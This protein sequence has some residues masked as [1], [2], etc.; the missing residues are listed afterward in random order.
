MVSR[1]AVHDQMQVFGERGPCSSV[2]LLTA[3]AAEVGQANALGYTFRMSLQFSDDGPE[4]PNAL[5]DDLARGEVVFLC[6]A[7]VSAPQMPGFKGLVD[8]IYKRRNWPCTPGEQLSFDKGRYEEGLGSL[9]RRLAHP[10]SLYDTV[11]SILQGPA[12]PDFSNHQTLLRLSRQL[13]NRLTIV[14]TNFDTM[15]ER[16]VNEREGLTAANEIS[17]AGQSLPAP[18]TPDFVGI[19][20]LHGRLEDPLLDLRRTPLVL[21]SAEYGDAYMRSGWAS[22]FL[23]DLTRCRTV[24]LVGYSAN[25]APVRYFLN[26]LEADRDR[27]SDLRTVYALDG[28][29]GSDQQPAFD[30]WSA[31]AVRTLL[32]CKRNKD[33][34]GGPHA[35]LWG[36]LALL[37]DLIEQPK[38]TRLEKAEAI[39]RRSFA[40]NTTRDQD[41]LAW[42]F[43]R[44]ADVFNL[45]I[46]TIQDPAWM[47]HLLERNLVQAQDAPWMLAEWCAKRWTDQA[48]VN[49][50]VRWSDRLGA[51]F[52]NE[53]E[54]R[55]TQGQDRPPPEPWRTAWRLL[56]IAA[57]GRRRD[58]DLSVFD[59]GVFFDHGAALDYDRRRAVRLMTPVLSVRELLQMEKEDQPTRVEDILRPTMEL[60]DEDGLVELVPSLLEPM[61]APRIAEL[62]TEELSSSLRIARDAGLISGS[63]D[64]PDED[65]PSVEAHPQNSHFRGFLPLVALLVQ[66]LDVIAAADVQQARRLAENWSRLESR[67][68]R[69]LWLHAMRRLDLFQ[70]DEAL[71]ALLSLDQNDFWT[72]RREWVQVAVE[73]AQ[74]AASDQI[75]ALVNRI[76]LEAPALYK[77][78][79]DLEE[80]QTDWRSGA[81]DRA[82][83]LRLSALDRSGRLNEVGKAS[84]AQIKA[85]HLRLD[86]DYDDEDL[87]AIYS[88]GVHRVVGNP[89]PLLEAVPGERLKI[90]HRLQMSPI[91]DDHESWSAYA[92]SDPESA[93][94]TLITGD[95]IKDA[96][97]W[98]GFLNMIA[99]PADNDPFRRDL[100]RC[101]LEK[102]FKHLEGVND[103]FLKA[104]I[105]ALVEG[106]ISAHQLEANLRRNWWAHLWRRDWWDRLWSIAEAEKGRKTPTNDGRFYDRVINSPGGRLTELLLLMINRLRQTGIKPSP[107]DLARLKKIMMSD[108]PAGHMGRGA[109][110]HDFGFVWSLVPDLARLGLVPR[111]ALETQ[112]GVALRT[113]LMDCALLQ[114]KATNAVK[115]AI[116]LGIRE[117]DGRGMPAAKLLF[118]ILSAIRKDP[119]SDRSFTGAE[120]REALSGAKPDVRKGAAFCMCEWLGRMELRPADGWRKLIGPLFE[121][122]WPADRAFREEASTQEL[123][124]LCVAAADAFPEALAVIRPFLAPFERAW[125][126][127]HFLK[128]SSAPDDFPSE[129]LDLVWVLFGPPSQSISHDLGSILDR[130]AAAKPRL[131]ADRRFQWLEDRAFRR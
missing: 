91:L 87:F 111:L 117:S 85:R 20:H 2:D 50:A 125:A 79:D 37:A 11:A 65:V 40:Y 41:T 46:D 59:L 89:A 67:L 78:P 116:L 69:R 62:A 120:V 118:P 113:V 4:F 55:V 126:N 80:G 35:A 95:P 90:A 119:D 25:D 97:L 21:T 94:K 71:T 75:D 29:D 101:L 53:L 100:S 61:A 128:T 30:A 66:L 77:D 19:I 105:H 74:D 6:G 122:T 112:E 127:I 44:R 1:S 15:F 12:Q 31:V 123:A 28:V 51:P 52:G 43:K 103:V 39:F 36:D 129:C 42:V 9:A 73:R 106:L 57:T 88:S 22:R 124:A 109:L 104:T 47:D 107:I 49:A 115:A 83:W 5:V 32:Y 48:A 16:A 24:V 130:I 23:F 34:E 76:L 27:F 8:D 102:A 114:P 14:T 58:S 72:I 70:P 38:L 3:A 54:L 13:D 56:G 63:R 64:E 10:A 86:R 121:A 68:G 93:L 33:A 110:V 82:A 17:I 99:H 92:A 131:S 84:L 60:V 96:A 26:V 98:S 81:R 45:A 18:G 7:G 108:T